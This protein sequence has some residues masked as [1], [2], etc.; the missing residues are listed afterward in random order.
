MKNKEREASP[1]EATKT[2]IRFMKENL[3]FPTEKDCPKADNLLS[4]YAYLKIFG[5]WGNLKS[6]ALMKIFKDK[7][8][9][10]D[11]NVRAERADNKISA[12]K[13]L[14]KYFIRNGRLPTELDCAI[15]S[16]LGEPEEY[17]KIYGDWS[18][19]QIEVMKNILENLLR[20]EDELR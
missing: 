8:R 10:R 16:E 6:E 7:E 14:R 12:T 1:D 5:S 19:M 3:R 15:C 20:L 18:N 17:K 2:I 13:K 4:Q 11:T 9:S